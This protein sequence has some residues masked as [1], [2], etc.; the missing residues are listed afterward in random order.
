VLFG[1]RLICDLITRER[2]WNENQYRNQHHSAHCD[3]P[4]QNPD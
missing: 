1:Y 2:E 3:S 4:S